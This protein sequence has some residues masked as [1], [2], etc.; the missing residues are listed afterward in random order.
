MENEKKK[1]WIWNIEFGVNSV[2]RKSS[3]SLEEMI[4]F[5]FKKKKKKNDKQNKILKS[6]VIDN[7]FKIYYRKKKTI[8]TC[9]KT[10]VNFSVRNIA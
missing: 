6:Y 10:I 8:R 2:T 3:Y 9:T 1:H 5:L 4:S 7:W